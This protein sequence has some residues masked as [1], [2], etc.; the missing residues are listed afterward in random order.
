MQNSRR[1]TSRIA[2]VLVSL[3][4]RREMQLTK[5]RPSHG[6]LP[7]FTFL[8]QPPREYNPVAVWDFEIDMLILAELSYRTRRACYVLGWHSRGKFTVGALGAGDGFR[9]STY[10]IIVNT[11]FCFYVMLGVEPRHCERIDQH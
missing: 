2:Y 4:S 11:W 9:L 8:H 1:Y 5:S 6:L 3:V 10:R 7:A